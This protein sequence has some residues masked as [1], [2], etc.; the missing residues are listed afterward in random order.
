MGSTVRAAGAVVWRP[1]AQ[2][3]HRAPGS[4]TPADVEI[5]LIHRPHYDDWSLPKG[6]LEAGEWPAVAAVREVI[7]EARVRPLLGVPLP[8]QSYV[9]PN[10]KTKV[11]DYWLARAET[12]EPS[13]DARVWGSVK[14]AQADEIDGGEWVPLEAAPQRL[15]Y[16]LDQ[17]L[18]REVARLFAAGAGET[19]P[20]TLGRHCKAKDR[21]GWDGSDLERPLNKRGRA[22]AEELGPLLAAR[23][24]TR[25]LTS[26]ARRCQETLAAH[27]CAQADTARELMEDAPWR[28]LA[29]LERLVREVL[30]DAAAGTTTAICT[31]EPTFRTIA[32]IYHTYLTPH[33]S[34]WSRGSA[35]FEGWPRTGEALVLHVRRG[36]NPAEI[37]AW[38]WLHPGRLAEL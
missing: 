34:A 29:G 31:H 28:D 22:Q 33:A 7:E 16:P 12:A 2:C 13:P 35:D 19:V 32:G 6:K 17:E 3:A 21:Y 9:M 25:H 26:P 27:P 18:V 38:E 36:V 15:T 37:V 10:G 8:Q 24:I 14:P 5:A 30:E 20:V 4:L 11:I 23:G 1:Q